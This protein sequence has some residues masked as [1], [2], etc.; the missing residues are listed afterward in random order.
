MEEVDFDLYGHVRGEVGCNDLSLIHHSDATSTFRQEG[1]PR[2]VFFEKRATSEQ[3]PPFLY[4]T[5][6]T[7]QAFDAGRCT[8]R[9]C[10]KMR[11]NS[12]N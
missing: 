6:V 4:A 12:F 11:L 5:L 10:F 8:S 3:R 2:L 7:H 1:V 9:H